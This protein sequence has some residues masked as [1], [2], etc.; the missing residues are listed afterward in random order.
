MMIVEVSKGMKV[1]RIE[2]RMV[3]DLEITITKDQAEDSN[4]HNL[5]RNISLQL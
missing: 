3:I 2:I 5:F 1:G 4:L